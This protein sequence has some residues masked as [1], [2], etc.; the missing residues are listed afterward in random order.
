VKNIDNKTFPN[1]YFSLN[2]KVGNKFL[3]LPPYALLGF[4]LATEIQFSSMA[5]MKPGLPDGIVSNQKYQCCLIMEGLATEDVGILY[6]YLVH[7]SRF[8]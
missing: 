7:F 4:D 2:I 5:E 1:K 3:K 8:W 6:G